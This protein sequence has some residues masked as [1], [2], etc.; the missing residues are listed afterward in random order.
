MSDSLLDEDS[1]LGVTFL[2]TNR[3]LFSPMTVV[4]HEGEDVAMALRCERMRTR[5]IENQDLF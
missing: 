3:E 4:V 5:H 1:G 2:V